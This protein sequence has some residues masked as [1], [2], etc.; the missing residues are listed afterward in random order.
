MLLKELPVDMALNQNWQS[1]MGSSIKTGLKFLMETIPDLKAVVVMVCDQ[2]LLQPSHLQALISQYQETGKPAIGSAYDNTLGVPALFDHTL[3][4]QILR[5]ED[6]R[7]AKQL[8]QTYKA[9]KINY[10]NGAVDLDT[11]ADYNKFIAT[12]RNHH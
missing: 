6:A 3:F 1:G 8:L 4:E 7:G 10:P 9:E 5:L 11:P 2:P 12:D